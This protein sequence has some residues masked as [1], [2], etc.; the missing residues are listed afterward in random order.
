M[1]TKKERTIEACRELAE[2]YR[3]P[4]GKIFFTSAQC[5]L[6]DIFLKN[7]SCIGC[8][9]AG[10]NGYIGCE[11]FDTYINAANSGYK[12]S[13]FGKCLNR[14]PNKQFLARAAFFDKII[15]I[16]EKAPASQFTK[17]GWKPFNIPLE[18]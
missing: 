6:C 10:S 7:H 14:K 17:K 4:Q 2:K 15:P 9:L 11:S 3:K 1:K 5:P 12:E 13:D 16:L 18:W 8:P